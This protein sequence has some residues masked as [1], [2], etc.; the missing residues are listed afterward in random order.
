MAPAASCCPQDLSGGKPVRITSPMGEVPLWGMEISPEQAR[1]ELRQL[2][3]DDNGKK[4]NDVRGGGR[5]A[6]GQGR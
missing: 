4:L 3:A 2:V 6:R 5:G 1:A